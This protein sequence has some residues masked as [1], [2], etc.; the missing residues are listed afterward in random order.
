MSHPSDGNSQRFEFIKQLV[1][2]HIAALDAGNVVEEAALCSAYVRY[3]PEL[4]EEL[5][6]A[7]LIR[8]ARLAAEDRPLSGLA[9]SLALG[10]TAQFLSI[11]RFFADYELLEL[12]GS[13]GFGRVYRARHRTTGAT[14]AIKILRPDRAND[15]DTLQ[16][17]QCEAEIARSL[18]HDN[19]VQ[20]QTIGKYQDHHYL[21]MEFVDG[22]NLQQ[23]CRG[24]PLSSLKSAQI[25]CGV[26]SACSYAHA[27]KIFHRDIKPGNILIEN[28]TH[29][30]LIT[31][32]GLAK[33]LDV[34]GP[35]TDSLHQ[36]GTLHYMPPEQAD[37]RLGPVGTG[38]DIYA[39]GTTLYYLLSGRLPF[40]CEPGAS[41]EQL[42][43]DIVWERPP[44]LGPAV[45]KDMKTLCY[46]CLQKMPV[47]RYGSVDQLAEDLRRF[48]DGKAIDT[49]LPG[50][51]RRTEVF[52]RRRPAVAMMLA[53]L[54]LSVGAGIWLSASYAIRATYY[55]TK[56]AAATTQTS[57]AQRKQVLQEYA[58]DM[59]N[60]DSIRNKGE[61]N[62]LAAILSKYEH[63]SGFD[64]RDFEWF[65][66]RNVC[67]APSPQHFESADSDWNRLCFDATG[68]RLATI[69]RKGTLIVWDPAT[70][71]TV[72]RL[73]DSIHSVVFTA[74]G[75]YC[76][77]LLSNIRGLVQVRAPSDG[78]ILNSIKTGPQTTSIAVTPDG[79]CLITA[80]SDGD[81][82]SRSLPSGQLVTEITA[83]YKNPLQGR[84]LD[85]QH[86]MILDMACSPDGMFLAT[87]L[88][89]GSVQIWDLHKRM[90]VCRGPNRHT[91]PV[92]GICFSPDGRFVAS[93][94]VG[95]YDSLKQSYVIG[96]TK[97]WEYSS[98]SP[99]C[100]ISPLLNKVADSP[101]L[102]VSDGIIPFGQFRPAFS[103]D[104]KRLFTTGERT[105][106]AW[107][108]S[109]GAQLDDFKGH[110]ALV[111]AIALSPD[112][113]QLAGAGTNHVVRV[114]PTSGDTTAIAICSHTSGIY[115]IALNPDGTQ[116]AAVCDYAD[117]WAGEHGQ[118]FVRSDRRGLRVWDVKSGHEVFS[119]SKITAPFERT[120][121]TANGRRVICGAMQY[122][123]ETKESSMLSTPDSFI[124]AGDSE[125]LASSDGAVLLQLSKYVGKARL[126]FLHSDRVPTLL[127]TP[128]ITSYA[129]SPD[130]R[131]VAIT[132]KDKL[133][134][135]WSTQNGALQRTFAGHEGEVTT[136]A[137]SP[138]S[139]KL[140]SGGM[141]RHIILWNV[142]TGE[143]LFLLQGHRREISSLAFSSN[144]RRLLSGSGLL[145]VPSQ[146]AGEIMLWDVETGLPTL[147]LRSGD[148]S[149]Y[150]G[151]AFSPDGNR[152][153][154]SCNAVGALS[155]GKIVAWIA[156]P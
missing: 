73:T 59:L 25:M 110:D 90:I 124:T 54:F 44:S 102:D 9:D 84:S 116:I 133:V 94:S 52:I 100:E 23:F 137:F 146:Q 97:I 114:W 141:D 82:F 22:V 153:Y 69:D 107:D 16:R 81:I 40:P 126:A 53:S 152:V 21:V 28:G 56:A 70:S 8:E 46:K 65:Y 112:G 111:L 132:G 14:V 39:L 91:G 12:L 75:K 151:V 79:K 140:A 139:T 31:D 58:A 99:V 64:P 47:D 18:K 129:M 2:A 7:R 72:Y 15:P 45:A 50:P 77:T 87:G 149:I 24:L 138:D 55:A 106:Q 117:F 130:N 147:T 49:R 154:A 108:A 32:F 109:S 80:N 134:R 38:S 51:V 83:K 74:D 123:P 60:V 35:T 13:G 135:L 29:R 88:A 148:V 92:T 156:N 30:P 1:E 131:W 125:E 93:Q 86:G 95:D 142:L 121:F 57:E 61:M 11:G 150:C 120:S 119:N 71:K 6:A 17:F 127:E 36:I 89:D 67:A 27:N 118:Q 78:Q 103:A 122:D 43:H 115:G 33:A 4:G 34:A 42:T 144:G 104:G 113:S 128:G 101:F 63:P 96:Q 136:L 155:P 41:R 48:I 62:R 66:L 76:L 26:A 98:G 85:I 105:V 3:M 68:K 20:I 143:K 10:G 5:R 19:I 37:R 145:R